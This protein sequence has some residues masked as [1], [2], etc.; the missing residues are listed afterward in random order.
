MTPCPE[1]CLPCRRAYGGTLVLGTPEHSKAQGSEMASGPKEELP[2]E[3]PSGESSG[4]QSPSALWR[5]LMEALAS[6][7]EQTSTTP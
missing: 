5:P 1:H 3:R 4:P 7:N 6:G 2:P